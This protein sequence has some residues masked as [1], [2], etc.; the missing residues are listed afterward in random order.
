MLAL[1]AM[2]K[3][4]EGIIAGSKDRPESYFDV[5]QRCEVVTVQGPS[6]VPPL[7]DRGL[8]TRFNEADLE[9]NSLTG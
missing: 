3:V 7:L 2:T 4:L 1:L 8:R 5:A 9:P 6:C